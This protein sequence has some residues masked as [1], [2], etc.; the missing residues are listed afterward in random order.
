MS[1]RRCR[2]ANFLR[3]AL[4]I[5]VW[6]FSVNTLGPFVAPYI[7]SPAGVGAPNIWL[8]IMMVITQASYVL[9]APPWGMV[10]DRF[11]RK[12][13]V[14]LGSLYPLS[15]LAYFFITPGNYM[16]IL[17]VTALVQGL[18]SFPILD[19]AGQLMLTLAPQRSRTGY[20]A[21]YVVI[22]GI[23][24][25]FGALLGGM[26]ED[27]LRGMHLQIVGGRP[28]RA[29]SRSSSSSASCSRSSVPSSSR[30]SEKA[31]RS[32]WGSCFPR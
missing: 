24:P 8:G 16:W 13:V 5:A 9:T 6:L 28:R 25:G 29:G 4:S 18:L 30:I 31:A 14:I 22:A 19:G 10:M 17:P 1:W 2:D 32:R 11:G 15:W 27:A 23:V 12:P 20:V 21:W 26:L 3:F 7:T